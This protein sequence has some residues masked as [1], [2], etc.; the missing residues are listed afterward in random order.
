MRRPRVVLAMH[1]TTAASLFDDAHWERLRSLAEVVDEAPLNSFGDDR[2]RSLLASAEVLLTGWGVPAIDTDALAL[3]PDLEAVVH[4]AGTVKGFISDACWARSLR[5]TS[6]AAANARPVAEF[7][8][9][10]ILLAGKAAFRAQAMYRAHRTLPPWP[11]TGPTPGNRGKRVGLIGASNVGRQVI[12]LLAPFEFDVVVSD[13]LLGSED[14][15]RLGVAVLDLDELLATADIVSVHAPLLAATTSLLDA[16]RLA[17]LTDGATLINTARGA[18]VDSIAL[19]AELMK[20]RISAVIDTTDPEPLPADSPL[21]DLPNVF[22]TP[23]IAGSTGT[24]LG[25]LAD[26]ALDELERFAAGV[27]FAHEITAEELPWIA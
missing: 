3:A 1:A 5:V 9:A 2:A 19:E 4:A 11:E 8:L 22:L 14:A 7:T 21:Y 20:G 26:A 24:E 25:R 6:V 23:H 10:A 27:A 12:R 13:P 18:I 15:G 16:R 17:L